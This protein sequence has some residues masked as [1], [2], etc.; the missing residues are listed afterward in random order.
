[1]KIIFIGGGNMAEAIF[2]QLNKIYTD[3]VVVDH[4]ES[5]TSYIKLNY[6]QIKHSFTLDFTPQQDD[7]IFLA[8]KPKDAPTSLPNLPLNNAI[9]ISLIAGIDCATI[10]KYLKNNNITRVM[11]NT[12]LQFGYGTSGIFFSPNV[13]SQHRSTIKKLFSA[14]G[15]NYEL[16]TEE[17]VNKFVAIA[18]SAPAYVYYLIEGFIAIAQNEFGFSAEDSKAITLQIFKG[19]VTAIEKSPQNTISELRRKVTSPNG[20]TE[21]AINVFNDEKINEILLKAVRA[22]YNKAKELAL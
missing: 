3:I 9:I 6:P 1:M 17:D 18:G 20:T 15:D 4:N 5:R 7:V 21:R 16:D 19:S 11:T 8:I 22:C 2:S 13:N 12:I 14:M 10:A